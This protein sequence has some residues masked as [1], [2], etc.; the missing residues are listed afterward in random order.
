MISLFILL[1]FI[2]H[3]KVRDPLSKHHFKFLAGD[4]VNTAFKI[5]QQSYQ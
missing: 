5:I 3:R 1:I 4:N 2:N